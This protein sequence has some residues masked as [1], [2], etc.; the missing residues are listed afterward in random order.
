MLTP[1][2]ERTIGHKAYT[3]DGHKIGKVR[4]VYLD[5]YTE[6]P[7]FVTVETG[8]FGTKESFVPVREARIDDDEL[9][10]PYDKDTVKNAPHAEVDEHL[11]LEEERKLFDYYGIPFPERPDATAEPDRRVLRKHV[12]VEDPAGTAPV[13][14]ERVAGQETVTDDVRVERV[15]TDD[16]RRR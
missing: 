6:E 5:D 14:E 13:R 2:L 4:G 7:N 1:E 12:V 11:S 16:D 9:V 10:L 8:L 3:P 15:E